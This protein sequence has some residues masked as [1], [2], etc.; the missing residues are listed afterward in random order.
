LRKRKRHRKT[1]IS[2]YGFFVKCWFDPLGEGLPEG[3]EEIDRP[4]TGGNGPVRVLGTGTPAHP[5]A[6]LTGYPRSTRG[7]HAAPD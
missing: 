5:L 7:V 4:A 3:G 6:P 1:I 2:L